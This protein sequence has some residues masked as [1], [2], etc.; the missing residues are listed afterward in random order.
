M[1]LILIECTMHDYSK[2]IV[3]A[4]NESVAKTIA[5]GRYAEEHKI[6]SKVIAFMRIYDL[7][8]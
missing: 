2:I 3:E 6:N 8:N 1:D 5:L 7:D 4:P